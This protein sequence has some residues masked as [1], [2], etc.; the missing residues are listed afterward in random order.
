VT[1]KTLGVDTGYQNISVYSESVYVHTP[2]IVV[3]LYL[4]L[5]YIILYTKWLYNWTQN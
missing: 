4:I 5:V 1:F 2:K 3:S